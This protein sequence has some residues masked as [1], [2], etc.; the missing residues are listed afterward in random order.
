MAALRFSQNEEHSPPKL[1]MVYPMAFVRL[2]MPLVVLLPS[3]IPSTKQK[4]QGHHY[5]NQ[6]FHSPPTL[7]SKDNY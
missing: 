4:R 7:A 1:E 6:E 3:T 5:R 2:I